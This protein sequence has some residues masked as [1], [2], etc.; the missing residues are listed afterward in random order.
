MTDNKLEVLVKA[1]YN[2]RMIL[3]LFTLVLIVICCSSDNTAIIWNGILFDF[4]LDKYIAEHGDSIIISVSIQNLQ[5]Y[6]V[7]IEIPIDPLRYQVFKDG[8]II[9]YYPKVYFLAF[10]DE[11]FLPNQRKNFSVIWNLTNSAGQNAPVGK[12]RLDTRFLIYRFE[13]QIVDSLDYPKFDTVIEVKE[14]R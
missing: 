13:N 6:T 10:Y 8:F 2:K 11:Y 1:I 9:D 5:P 12:Y 7:E 14:R 4:S 3:L